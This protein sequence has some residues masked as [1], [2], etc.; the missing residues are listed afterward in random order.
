MPL[1][2]GPAASGFLFFRC[3]LLWHVGVPCN[4]S[5]VLSL[6]PIPPIDWIRRTILAAVSKGIT[7]RVTYTG[8]GVNYLIDF[9]NNHGRP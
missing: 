1:Q 4:T 3:V 7:G 5:L 2:I 6:F 9:L 8:F